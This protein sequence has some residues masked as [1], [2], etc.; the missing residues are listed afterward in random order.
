MNGFA[1][2]DSQLEAVGQA[3]NA[4]LATAVYTPSAG[5]TGDL[6]FTIPGSVFTSNPAAQAAVFSALQNGGTIRIV[7]AADN[8]SLAF[9]GSGV[10][11]RPAPAGPAP[12]LSLSYH[13]TVGSP[14]ILTVDQSAVTVDEGTT[15]NNSGTVSDPD[16]IDDV[17]SVTS[18][19]GTVTWTAG[20]GTWTWSY[21]TTDGPANSGTVTSTARRCRRQRFHHGVRSIRQQ[22]QPGRPPA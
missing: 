15:A 16:G 18:D 12:S 7:L 3:G 1:M 9:S 20:S 4:P 13:P 19:V 6:I 10:A 22:R 2:L 5:D 11:A 21:T 17:T 8:A 14:S